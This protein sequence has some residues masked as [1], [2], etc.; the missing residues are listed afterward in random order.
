MEVGDYE[1]GVIEKGKKESM[2]KVRE[3]E[4]GERV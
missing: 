1:G 4:G 3:K 2:R